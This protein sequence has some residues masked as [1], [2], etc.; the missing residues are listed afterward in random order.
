[1]SERGSFVTEYIHCSECFRGISRAL[2]WLDVAEITQVGQLPILAGK[3]CGMYA[4]E[5]LDVFENGRERLEAGICPGH[6]VRIAVL[7]DSADEAGRDSRVFE[8]GQAPKQTPRRPASLEAFGSFCET[9]AFL[10]AY[11]MGLVGIEP[12]EGDPVSFHRGIGPLDRE[13]CLLICRPGGHGAG[14]VVVSD[15]RPSLLGSFDDLP[16]S[17]L[18]AEQAIRQ[19]VRVRLAEWGLS[20]EGEGQHGL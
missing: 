15:S 13:V 1:M 3:V 10:E 18:E 9:A 20:E 12:K 2:P 4:S 14:V 17:G 11:S 16:A 7:S 8:F 6:R 19:E 5:E